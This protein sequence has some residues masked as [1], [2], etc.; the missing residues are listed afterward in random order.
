VLSDFSFWD[1]PYTDVT[2]FAALSLIIEG[3]GELLFFVPR[4][5][6]FNFFLYDRWVR[7]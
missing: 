4:F 1:S 7:I 5:S 2:S 6:I 3:V